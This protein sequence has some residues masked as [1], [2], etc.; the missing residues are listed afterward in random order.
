MIRFVY[1]AGSAATRELLTNYILQDLRK[2]EK[3]LLLVPEQETVSVERR[4][5]AQLTGK[6][7]GDQ[8][9]IPENTLRADEAMFLDNM[10][11]A[12]LSKQ[13][14]VSIRT[15]KNNGAEFIKEMLGIE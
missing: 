1:N 9:I 5:L 2:G 7:L 12:E 6:E 3:A 11:P 14:G 13:L 8:L 10:T 4:M 15:G